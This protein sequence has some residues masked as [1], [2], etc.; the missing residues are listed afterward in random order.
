MS[1]ST[2]DISIPELICERVRSSKMR[3]AM[4]SN[5]AAS[6]LLKKFKVNSSVENE[7]VFQEQEPDEYYIEEG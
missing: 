3:A 4:A 1:Y 7:A 2:S 5:I 6:V